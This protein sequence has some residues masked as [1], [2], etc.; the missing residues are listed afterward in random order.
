MQ[1]QIERGKRPSYVRV[2]TISDTTLTFWW[3]CL[4]MSDIADYQRVGGRTRRGWK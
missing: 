4:Q 2:Q 3:L 1:Q